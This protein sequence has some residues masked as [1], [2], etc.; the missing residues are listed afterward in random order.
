M[1]TGS[2][3]CNRFHHIEN[4]NFYRDKIQRRKIVSEKRKT[5]DYREG[6]TRQSKP[7]PGKAKKG[8]FL[9]LG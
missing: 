6:I 5:F 1:S 3:A 2:S 9:A 8:T 4:S 7:R